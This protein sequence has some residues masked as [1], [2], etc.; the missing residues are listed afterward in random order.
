[1]HVYFRHTATRTTRQSWMSEIFGLQQSVTLVGDQEWVS[2]DPQWN[3]VLKWESYSLMQLHTAL[4]RSNLLDK[5][6]LDY[7]Q[8]SPS[9]RLHETAVFKRGKRAR[10]I[11]WSF[12]LRI[13]IPVFP[14]RSYFIFLC[15]F[16]YFF[17][18]LCCL[19]SIT[20]PPYLSYL[21]SEEN[22]S[23]WLEGYE[24]LNGISEDAGVLISRTIN[25]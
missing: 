3:R 11:V 6:K 16:L 21:Q 8:V 15:L 13:L 12:F 1:M 4:R 22:K 23:Q 19:F 7:L 25:A 24:L 17:L 9:C 18:H 20:F 14:S 2:S 5:N 10:N